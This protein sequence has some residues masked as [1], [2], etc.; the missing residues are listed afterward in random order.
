MKHKIHNINSISN[1]TMKKLQ[2]KCTDPLS[3]GSST[4]NVRKV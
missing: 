3:N 4:H 1:H 2:L